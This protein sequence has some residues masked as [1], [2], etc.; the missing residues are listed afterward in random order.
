MRLEHEYVARKLNGEVAE[1]MPVP[2]PTNFEPMINFK[3]AKALGLP[4]SPIVLMRAQKVI[5]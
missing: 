5:S 1:L 3:T 4:I 2:E